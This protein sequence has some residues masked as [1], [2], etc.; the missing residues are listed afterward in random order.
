MRTSDAT[1]RRTSYFTDIR[2]NPRSSAE[3]SAC[4]A[5]AHSR[6]LIAFSCSRP[7]Q[8]I[9]LN[10]ETLHA[11]NSIRSLDARVDADG[12]YGDGATGPVQ[13]A[14]CDHG[15]LAYRFEGF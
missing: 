2:G 14:R 7:A 10:R 8:R 4:R 11:D 1:L 5:F 12:G 9:R 6:A 13:R 15:P 3:N